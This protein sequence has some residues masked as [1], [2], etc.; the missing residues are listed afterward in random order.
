MQACEL[1]RE[2]VTTRTNTT[3]SERDE[4]REREEKRCCRCGMTMQ[5]KKKEECVFG[6]ARACLQNS[7]YFA[8]THHQHFEPK[9]LEI[10]NGLCTQMN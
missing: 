4:E 5:K 10:P 7:V 8:V 3:E 6:N 2:N 1:E 9:L